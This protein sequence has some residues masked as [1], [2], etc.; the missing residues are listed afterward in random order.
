[1]NSINPGMIETEGVRS[2]GISESDFRKWVEAQR[3]SDESD[4]QTTLLHAVYLA[5]SDSKY[6]TV[7]NA[8]GCGAA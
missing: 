6:M 4:R 1:V 2:A 5:S 7:R 3:H 8:V